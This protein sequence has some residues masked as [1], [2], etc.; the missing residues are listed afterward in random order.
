MT[1]EHNPLCCFNG[2]AEFMSVLAKRFRD[3][4][5]LW[6]NITHGMK[7]RRH[8]VNG[9]Y[10]ADKITSYKFHAVSQLGE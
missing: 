9:V 2:K 4:N 10:K 7:S 5:L 6:K 3:A 1:G 8:R